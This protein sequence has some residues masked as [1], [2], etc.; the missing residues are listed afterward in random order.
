MNGTYVQSTLSNGTCGDSPLP[1]CFN[2]PNGIAV[3]ASGNLYIANTSGNNVI[4]AVPSGGG[5]YTL[6]TLFSKPFGGVYAPQGIALDANHNVYVTD[7]TNIDAVI[8]AYASTGYTTYTL[9][10]SNSNLG[11]STLGPYGIAVDSNLNVFVGDSSDGLIEIP[12][13]GG[14]WGT[15]V[16]LG[17]GLH[18][19]RGVAVDAQ[20]NVYVANAGAGGSVVEEVLQYNGT[21]IQQTIAASGL[22][23][24]DSIAVDNRYNIYVSVPSTNQVIEISPFNGNFGNVN[25]GSTSAKNLTVTFEFFQPGILSNIIAVQKGDNNGEFALVP[26]GTNPCTTGGS[27]YNQGDTCT[28]TVNFTPQYAGTRY[29][30][31][32]LINSY[33]QLFGTGYIFGTGVGPQVVFLPGVVNELG[34][35]NGNGPEV[36]MAVD[37]ND[38]VFYVSQNDQYLSEMTA[39]SNY[40]NVL[41]VGGGINLPTDVQT[42]GAGNAYVTNWSVGVTYKFFAMD[43]YATYVSMAV[44]TSQPTG[45]AIDGNGN[46]Y[47]SSQTGTVN[48]VLASS[49]YTQVIQLTSG[50]SVPADLAV[51]GAGDVFVLNYGNGTVSELVAVN[52]AVPANPTILTVVTGLSIPQ[53]IKTDNVGNLF[54][55]DGGHNTV[56]EYT[57]ASGY[58]TKV[59]AASVI[60]PIDMGLDGQGNLFYNAGGSGTLNGNTFVSGEI[61]EQSQGTAPSLYFNAT[62]VGNT[63]TDIPQTVTI[64]NIGTRALTFPVLGSGNNPS[65]TSDFWWN[66]GSGSDCQLAP[67]SLAVQS[68]CAFPISFTP[69]NGGSIIGQLV[70]TDNTLYAAAPAYGQQVINL[71]GTGLGAAMTVTADS[72]TISFGQGIP[73]F[74][75][76]LNGPLGSAMC[77]GAPSIVASPQPVG[78]IGVYTLTITKGTLNCGPKYTSFVF[79]NGTLTITKQT[80]I[81]TLTTTN[82]SITYGQAIP[83]LASNY[84]LTGWVNGDTQATACTGAPVISTTA[85]AASPVGTYPILGDAGSLACTLDV[86]IIYTINIVNRG[87]LTIGKDTPVITWAPV[88]NTMSYG[89]AMVAGQFDA[90]ATNANNSSNVSADGT[91]VYHLTNTTGTVISVG[92]I[93]P[94]GTDT[95]CA[96]WTPITFW[97]TDFNSA[98]VCITMAIT[99]Q[100]PTIQWTPTPNPTFYGVAPTATD[101]QAAAFALISGVNTNISADGTFAYYVSNNC[102]GTTF[103]NATVL[104]VGTDNVSVKW[105]PTSAYNTQFTSVC[106][107]TTITVQQAATQINWTPSQT[108]WTYGAGVTAGILDAITVNTSAG[109][110][111]ISAQGTFTYKYGATA[112]TVGYTTLPLG[113]DSICV[114]WVPTVPA[115]YSAPAQVCQSFT[116]SI[117]TPTLGWVPP[118]TTLTYG[119]TVGAA[120]INATLINNTTGANTNDAG[121]GAFTY[122][123]YPNFPLLTG[124]SAVTSGTKLPG[125]TDVVCVTWAPSSSYTSDFSG[126]SPSSVCVTFTINPATATLTLT[127]TNN[128]MVYGAAVPSVA[129]N[130]TLT[131]FNS[132]DTQANSCTGTPNMSTTATSLSPVGSYPIT[133][134]T[135]APGNLSCH[136]SNYTYSIT[137]ANSGHMSITKYTGNLNLTASNG[138]SPYGI[139]PVVSGDYTLTGFVGADNQ[140]NVCTGVPSVTTTATASTPAGVYPNY[141]T[142]ALGSENCGSANAA[143]TI[144]VGATKGT[145]TITQSTTTISWVPVLPSPYNYPTPIG[146]GALDATASIDSGTVAITS[147]TYGTFSYYIG[148]VG[149]PALTAASVLPAG[150][151]TICVQFVPNV[152]YSPD[153][154]SASTCLTVTVGKATATLTLATTS[155][156]VPYGTA[157]PSV[158]NDYTL[159]GFVT[160]DSQATNCTGT[161][162]VTTTAVINDPVGNYP[163]TA[164]TGAPGNLVCTS[165]NANYTI[166]IV[167]GGNVTIT[168]ATN[169]PLTITTTNQTITYGT[170]PNVTGDYTLSG[171]IGTDTSAVCS[172]TPNITTT[173]VLNSPVGTYPIAYNGAGTLVCGSANATY[174]ITT[175]NNT[176]ILTIIDMSGTGT[177]YN[178]GQV[179]I[180]TTSGPDTLTFTF[181][182]A[183][184]IGNVVVL[185]EGITGLDFADAGTGTCD[186]NGTGHFYNIGDT[187]TVNVTFTPKYPGLRTGAVEILDGDG[188]LV[189]TAFVQGVGVGPEVIFPM[190]N[191]TTNLP[192][193]TTTVT[194][195]FLS[196]AGLAIDGSNNIYVT[197]TTANTVTQVIAAGGYTTSN[198]VGTSG[199]FSAPQGIAIDGA[200]NLFVADSGHNVVKEIVA[201]GGYATVKSIYNSTTSPGGVAIDGSGNLFITYPN[202]TTAPVVE[203]TYASG[204]S[205]ATII[206]ASQFTN[207]GGISL[208]YAGNLYVNDTGAGKLFE[209]TAASSYATISTLNSALTTPTGLVLDPNANA[210]ISQGG[211]TSVSQLIANAYTKVNNLGSLPG[212]IGYGLALDGAADLFAINVSTHKVIEFSYS[213]VPSLTFLSTPYFVTS[214]DSPQ[215]VGVFNFGNAD[216]NLPVPGSGNDPAFTSIDFTLASGTNP[217]CPLVTSTTANISASQY[218]TLPISYTPLP[219]G[220]TTDTLTLTDNNLNVANAQ[221]V[222]NGYF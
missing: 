148:S 34:V 156:S 175:V 101:F 213:A 40:T 22:S 39:A 157:I 125:G 173:A 129:G 32:E 61:L 124:G 45:S 191:G 205:S 96:V 75:Y 134:T 104:P 208:D 23:T 204:Y 180:G 111:N 94:A 102:T 187:C 19:S 160:G 30:A 100:T 53:S 99:G 84:T 194:T 128:T 131:G 210:Y 6:S 147:P 174:T 196:P 9:L 178:F 212:G 171:F 133:A 123:Y 222:I 92:T 72:Y 113:T 20:N 150:T 181:S 27:G 90:V 201:D 143:Y 60:N 91:F 103:S 18:G 36:A 130:Y 68:F 153:I 81:L 132:P 218:C 216:L 192:A 33:N 8:V 95:L 195:T 58:V 197:D 137:I 37:G 170:T 136:S 11:D 193:S 77:T 51:D 155:V 28:V 185:T 49:D 215:T 66:Q 35:S 152:T 21:Y 64:E 207:A 2:A 82:A 172:G 221:Q 29:G 198:G 182:T 106:Y 78:A 154:T 4:K 70:L 110:T 163:I 38:N 167:N 44:G 116:V 15:P 62:I 43:N 56:D 115:N 25:I 199:G 59:I 54:I 183:G 121:F 211:G 85:T 69:I 26:G 200:G 145:L 140:G 149:G 57:V 179:N 118:T 73:T 127:T 89:T 159:T 97:A 63:S 214:S 10:D 217:E 177:G 141:I 80:V 138:S 184:D 13:S 158:V 151:D 87:V 146:A 65:I 14:T 79:N 55:A 220:L 144:I 169:V 105:T 86:N 41:R 186:T 135:G 114:N 46:V 203:L 122:T 67:Y 189:A 164:T 202:S 161:P 7:V 112:I 188:N 120:N 108:S 119:T 109:G 50:L 48:E 76:Q 219:S 12:Y 88:P 176:G 126:T 162:N 71:N 190:N 31:I 107:T 1:A 98:S 74:G 209:F 166:N 139:T 16:S 3:D 52:G 206:G 42:D 93:L 117:A 24:V 168:Q 165:S 17:S 47:I 5:L 83:S 142:A